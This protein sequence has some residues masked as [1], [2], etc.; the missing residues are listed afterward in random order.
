MKKA[1]CAGIDVGATYVKIGLVSSG[2]KIVR[3]TQIPSKIH[4]PA[5]EMLGRTAETIRQMMTE[6]GYEL[7]GIGIGTAGQVDVD[8]GIL[9]EAPNMPDWKEV[10]VGDIL[11]G[12]LDMPVVL[13]NDAN[14]AAWGEYAFG[15][16]RG[17]RFM[18]MVTLGTGVGGGMVLDGRPYRGI[19]N[20][21]GEFGHSTLDM[22]GWVCGC[23]RRGC[24][25]AYVGTQGFKRQVAEK[26]KAGR[27]SLLTRIDPEVLM[28]VDISRAAD[29]G[30]ALAVEVFRDTGVY[31]G[32][33][34]A[35]VVNLLN[36]ER[37]VIGGGVAKAGER[38]L[39]P[40]RET[41]HAIC[42]RVPS[43][44]VEIVPAQLGN[45]AGIIG[46]AWMAGCLRQDE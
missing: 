34:I 32:H 41:V 31:L 19:T 23:G 3:K 36:L 10:P 14:V 38:I 39:G 15:A 27:T 20:A 13:D 12:H 6:D 4:A 7:A 35:D 42:L 24:V 25:E 40:A 44:A 8:K 46:A 22:D 28:P 21:A 5:A 45:D 2:G 11:G 30:D 26:L 29:E 43:N 1:M 16:G 18:L 9:H 37:V 33:A 17:T